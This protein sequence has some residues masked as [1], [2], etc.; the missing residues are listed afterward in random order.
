[1]GY[2]ALKGE[3]M[4]ADVDFRTTQPPANESGFTIIELLIAMAI[5][6]FGLVSIV[7]LSAYVSRANMDSNITS[8]LVTAVQTRVDTLKSATWNVSSCDPALQVGG[9]LTSNST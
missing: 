5:L 7:G 4:F 9:S 2:G 1:M 3:I 6:T 8:V